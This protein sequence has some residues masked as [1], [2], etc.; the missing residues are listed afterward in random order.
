MSY[1]VIVYYKDGTNQAYDDLNTYDQAMDYV[2][3]AFD[4][5]YDNIKFVEITK[6]VNHINPERWK[7][8]RSIE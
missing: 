5:E 3:G 8:E 6:C 2:D 1:T 7:K 4:E